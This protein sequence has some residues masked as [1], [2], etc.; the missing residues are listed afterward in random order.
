MGRQ[1]KIEFERGF[2]NKKFVIVLGIEF[3]IVLIHLLHIIFPAITT[4]IPF[5]EQYVGTKTDFIPGAMYYWIG[6][7]NS[8]E[9]TV[10]FAI[11]PILCA[12]P[13][14]SSLYTDDVSKYQNHFIVRE[15]RKNYFLSKLIT[16]FING[17][18]IGAFPFL[19]SLYANLM[20]LPVEQTLT[21]QGYFSLCNENIIFSE[22]FFSHPIIYCLI[23]IF[24]VF[25]GFGL[26]N[27]MCY[28]FSYVLSNAAVVMISSFVIYFSSLVI[29]EFMGSIPVA[30]QF[31]RFNQIKKDDVIYILLQ[32]VL[33][34]LLPAII[35]IYKSRK[36]V[37]IL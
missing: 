34:I 5:L 23:Y 2:K 1:L 8:M 36:R 20:L 33:M 14:S 26:I 15:N 30:W 35:A 28:V 24:F 3:V 12:I 27:C 9:R 22:L 11:M 16:M 31:M 19:L 25:I 18:V 7:N 21:V 17:G 10:L 32:L 6:L 29:M 4:G 13:Y 37:D